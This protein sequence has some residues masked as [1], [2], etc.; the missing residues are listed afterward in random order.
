MFEFKIIETISP[1]NKTLKIIASTKPLRLKITNGEIRYIEIVNI[2]SI[3]P[4][5]YTITY[6]NR[7]TELYEYPTNQIKGNNFYNLNTKKNF[8]DYELL[9][10]LN[11]TTCK[12]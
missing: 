3:I 11:T 1:S 2:K 8:S 9:K 5:K 6:E 7:I 4:I 10:N 12:F